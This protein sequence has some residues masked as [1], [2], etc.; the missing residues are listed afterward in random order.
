MLRVTESVCEGDDDAHVEGESVP[1]RDN[2]V[3]TD[4]VDDAESDDVMVTDRHC[5]TEPVSV[6][7]VGDA[8]SVDPAGAQN[9]PM[10]NVAR[11]VPASDSRGVADA[12]E[13]EPVG[14]GR[15]VAI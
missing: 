14:D 6:A 12:M 15:P 11:C 8:D 7:I 13:R 4:S 5:V 10:L 1:V 3:V 9:G 2:D